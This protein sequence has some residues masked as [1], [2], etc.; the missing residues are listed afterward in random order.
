M[1]PQPKIND[2]ESEKH[3]LSELNDISTVP[4]NAQ[5]KT[6]FKTPSQSITATTTLEEAKFLKLDDSCETDALPLLPES[7]VNSV[8][9]FVFFVGY[10]RSG[11][12]MIGS[13]MDAHPDMI[14]AHEYLLFVLPNWN[15]TTTYFVIS[16]ISS[17]YT[18]CKQL[19]QCTV[20]LEKQ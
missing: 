15:K 3:I 14:I 19:F 7:T 17:K 13:V 20:W 10:R 8:E 16:I 9:K 1:P 18:L 2:I 6:A 4:T 5:S 12:S 11:H